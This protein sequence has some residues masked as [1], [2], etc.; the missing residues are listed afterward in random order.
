MGRPVR[1]L[2][3]LIRIPAIL[4]WLLVGVGLAS[5][6]ALAGPAKRLQR[7][8]R[9]RVADLW[10]SG[11]LHFIGVKVR[12]T[13]QP[14]AGTV[15]F[16]ANHV[17]W[18]DILVLAS[19]C[20]ARFVSKAEVRS[21]PLL[22]WFAKEGGSVFIRRGDSASF[23]AVVECMRY[24]LMQGERLI[25]FPEGTTSDGRTL[26]RFRARLFASATAPG[27]SVQPVG[28]RYTGQGE[29]ASS[30]IPFVGEDTILANL[31]RILLL[32]PIEA[33]MIFGEPISGER[34]TARELAGACEKEIRH[35]LERSDRPSPD[36][37]VLFGNP[38]KAG[39]A[40]DY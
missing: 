9:V 36:A 33:E 15:L 23:T 35:W 22:G 16:A 38:E 30:C 24:E 27:I 14:Q 18:M 3:R 39:D 37:V 10:L 4:L 40:P 12:I 20:R 13:G 19:V 11:A 7:R 2:V 17:T 28:L 31:W 6:V 25:F 1:E 21:W 8:L 34:H 5:L 26:R 32:T 29:E